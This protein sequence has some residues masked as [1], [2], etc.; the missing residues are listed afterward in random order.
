MQVRRR[1]RGRLLGVVLAAAVPL[2]GM[3]STATALAAPSSSASSGSAGSPQKNDHGFAQ[4]ASRYERVVARTLPVSHAVIAPPPS[5]GGAPLGAAKSSAGALNHGALTTTTPPA[6]PPDELYRTEGNTLPSDTIEFGQGDQNQGTPDPSVAVGPTQIA[7][8]TNSALWVYQT[9][10]GQEWGFDLDVFLNGM[11]PYPEYTATSARIIYDAQSERWF[12]TVLDT[13]THDTGRSGDYPVFD[14]VLVSPT[15]TLLKTDDW[16]GFGWSPFKAVSDGLTGAEPGLGISSNLVTTTQDAYDTATGAFNESEMLI[17]QKS[18]LLNQAVTF[19]GNSAVD[20]QDGPL[21]PQPVQELGANQYQYVVWN[22]SDAAEGGCTPSCSIGVTTITGTPEAH[23]VVLSPPVYEPMSPTAVQCATTCSNPPASQLG[24]TGTLQ[25]GND[26]FLNAVWSGNT[27]WTADG[28]T[29]TP[30]GDTAPRSCL[31]YV[32]VTADASG[33]VG[34]GTQINDVSVVGASLS[35]PAVTIDASGN[36]YTVFDESSSTTYES[37]EMGVVDAGG[38][39]LTNVINVVTSATYMSPCGNFPAIPCTWGAYS[40]AAI[41]PSHPGDAWVVSEFNDGYAG[42]YCSNNAHIC[43]STYMASYTLDSPS[44]TSLSVTNGPVAGGQA[45]TLTGANFGLD[46]TVSFGGSALS[47]APATPETFTLLTPQ[48]ATTGGTVQV[49]VTDAL[50]ASA[51]SAST[52]YTYIGLANFVPVTPF[53]ILDTRYVQ[54]GGPFGPGAIRSLQVTGD[55][56]PPIPSTATAAVLNVTAVSGTLGSL[57]TVYPDGEARPNV[58]NLNFA[59]GVVVA[60]LVTVSLGADGMVDI[61]NALGSVNVLVDVEGYFTPQP[62][63]DVQGLFH[64]IAPVRVC[65]TRPKSPTPACTAHGPLSAKS[66]MVVQLSSTGGIPA[67]GTAEAAVVNLTGVAGTGATYLSMFPTN[68][69]GGCS[70]GGKIPAPFSMIN[71]IPG[72]VQA[73]RVMVELGPSTPGGH[74]DAICV[75]NAAGVINFLIDANGWYGSTTAPATPAGY[76]YQAIAPIRICDTRTSGPSVNNDCLGWPY[77]AVGNATAITLSVAGVLEI[78]SIHSDTTV[79]AFIA[80]LTAV[81][82][83][84]ATFLTLYPTGLAHRPNVSDINASAGEV[85]P[86]LVV[87]ELGANDGAVDLYNAAGTTNAIIDVEGWFQ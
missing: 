77:G 86:N 3:F 55:G 34:A 52:A 67:D 85:L 78:P 25:T 27:I 45:M 81:A 61:Y 43:W 12:L 33:N 22:N 65:D 2:F 56:T 64:A 21:S 82:P 46:S 15:S 75:Y 20:V 72:Q 57:L 35:F 7:E 42:S 11:N 10:I 59:R 19:D 69:S 54:D 84:E 18:D 60:N 38:S 87:V 48:H 51:E 83:I 79:V 76:Q 1:L 26:D 17:I 31:D 44:I 41:D 62:V 13:D 29:C 47:T 32:S 73:N 39:T 8:V 71:L 28:T 80:N 6:T 50:G 9:S 36:M 49:Q 58:S 68:A 14:W 63:S 24:T 70:Y 16:Y 53:R 37:I 66:S 4:T 30:S 5:T 23:D 74:D 40:G